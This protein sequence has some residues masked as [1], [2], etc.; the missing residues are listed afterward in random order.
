MRKNA[1]KL[2][3]FVVAIKTRRK[4]SMRTRLL[5]NKIKRV[6]KKICHV[7]C[8]QLSII[9]EVEKKACGKNMWKTKPQSDNSI[10]KTSVFLN[11]YDVHFMCVLLS[12]QTYLTLIMKLIDWKYSYLFRN[13]NSIFCKSNIFMKTQ[14]LEY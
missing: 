11:V 14:K 5:T 3:T 4:S 2:Q 10:I 13:S 8:V 9:D 1:Y 12:V 7:C 6:W